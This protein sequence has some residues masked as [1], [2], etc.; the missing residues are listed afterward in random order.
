MRI[1]VLLCEQQPL[2]R[3]GIRTALEREP[4]IDI[5]GEVDGS[6]NLITLC[7]RLHPDV[8][9]LGTGLPG[10]NCI[11]VARQLHSSSTAGS[12]AVM[13]ILSQGTWPSF[14]R[15]AMRAGA[16]GLLL[17]DG[18]PAEL[19]RA[20]RAVAEGNAFIAAP[21]LGWLLDR[22]LRYLPAEDAEPP[23]ALRGLTKRQSEVLR[24][25]AEGF[26]NAQI[27]SQLS[28][29]ETTV[30]SHVSHLLHK[31]HLNRRA[32]LITLA[33]QTG[34]ML[35]SRPAP[36]HAGA[37][38]LVPAPPRWQTGPLEPHQSHPSLVQSEPLPPLQVPAPRPRAR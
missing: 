14:T 29:D 30:K 17:A 22:Y 31:L 19:A 28:L 32:Q 1:R 16:R 11:D 6:V 13:V 27:A 3:L 20:I 8:V 10:S 4:D 36:G 2:L 23:A 15:A 12:P 37:P 33:H 24:L 9:I 38:A 26:S 21:I 7:R 25:V 18:P 5:A 34:L 35:V